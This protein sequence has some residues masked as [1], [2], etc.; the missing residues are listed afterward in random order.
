MGLSRAALQAEIRKAGLPR[1]NER[2]GRDAG[3]RE[4]NPRH[5]LF[6]V[7]PPWVSGKG[8]LN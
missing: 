6:D 5:V 4:C 1:L 2:K 8:G 7:S 3:N